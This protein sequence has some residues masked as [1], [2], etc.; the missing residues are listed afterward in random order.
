MLGRQGFSSASCKDEIYLQLDQLSGE[1]SVLVQSGLYPHAG[2]DS[3]I[4]LLTEDS[5]ADARYSGAAI[6]LAPA[7]NAYPLDK[8][9]YDELRQRTAIRA[10]AKGILVV[11]NGPH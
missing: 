6:V 9:E 1:R 4:Q 5:L 2:Y 10:T 8:R 3:R 7:M 11:R